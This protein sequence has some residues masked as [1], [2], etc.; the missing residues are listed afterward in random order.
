V[1]PYFRNQG[2]PD[3]KIRLQKLLKNWLNTVKRFF[4][5]PF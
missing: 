1:Y 5:L 4:C 2:P 3:A